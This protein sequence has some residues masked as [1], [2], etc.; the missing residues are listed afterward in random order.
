M[1]VNSSGEILAE[2]SKHIREGHILPKVS[3][4]FGFDELP[5]A[6]TV[7]E[8]G[9]ATGKV[10]VSVNDDPKEGFVKALT[11]E[12]IKTIYDFYSVF[13]KRDYSVVDRILAP[14]W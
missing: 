1:F 7:V 8:S 12:E 11:Q 14:D 4:V 10:V 9:R 13:S 5:Q 3:R 6:Q 2:I